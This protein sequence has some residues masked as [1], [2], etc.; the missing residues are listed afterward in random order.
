MGSRAVQCR[1]MGM[2][3]GRLARGGVVVA[4]AL[5]ACTPGSENVG[6]V[7]DEGADDGSGSIA[8][9]SSSSGDPQASEGGD[10]GTTGGLPMCAPPELDGLSFRVGDEACDLEEPAFGVFV[11]SCRIAGVTQ[12][13]TPTVD[14]EDCVDPEMN[15]IE[16]LD[17]EIDVPDL[18]LP[19][20]AF[21][22]DTTVD[23]SFVVRDGG[24]DN[25]CRVYSWLSLRRADDGVLLLALVEDDG[26]SVLPTDDAGE[27]IAS[28]LAPLSA[29][30]GD[31]V[32]APDPP[33]CE[34]TLQ[35]HALAIEGEGAPV[36]V[37]SGERTTVDGFTVVVGF[38]GQ[39]DNCEGI[40]T[41]HAVE[42]AFV[43]GA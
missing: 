16:N 5:V 8:D 9:G 40:P 23:V 26:G 13:E 10:E 11:A 27:E 21:A 31:A 43:A 41:H 28:W 32:C 34:G 1:I 14:L 4:L 24:S 12:G 7:A 20:T 2:S 15:A 3:G 35:R 30:L 37:A 36:H 18:A 6:Q 38:A 29:T 17:V 19:P 22:A 42:A 25:P 33:D 39:S